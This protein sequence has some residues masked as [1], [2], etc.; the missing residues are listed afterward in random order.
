MSA[1]PE[2]DELLTEIWVPET[3]EGAEEGYPAGRVYM[4]GYRLTPEETEKL[5]RWL[6]ERAEIARRA[7]A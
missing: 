4:F 5:A 6:L 3:D 7:A 1:T 2:L